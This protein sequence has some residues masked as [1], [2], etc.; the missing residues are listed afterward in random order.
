MVSFIYVL[1]KILIC[2][3][4]GSQ[5]PVSKNSISHTFLFFYAYGVHAAA[6]DAK[7]ISSPVWDNCVHF[8]KVIHHPKKLGIQNGY[9]TVQGLDFIS[10][11]E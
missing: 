1:S 10:K 2:R 6:L 11:I 3:N 9:D 5:T 7:R 8:G 4:C